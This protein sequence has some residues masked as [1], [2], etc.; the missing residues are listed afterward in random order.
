MAQEVIV[1][2]GSMISGIV[3]LSQESNPPP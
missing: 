1:H 2:D 3:V